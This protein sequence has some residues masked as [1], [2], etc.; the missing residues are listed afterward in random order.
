MNRAGVPLIEIVTK[1]IEGAGERAPEVARAY[2]TA[3]RD[4][5]RS[6]KVSDVN[7]AQGS[8]RADVN[9]SLRPVGTTEFGTRTETKNV[10]TLKSIE[11]AV[12]YE[13]CRQA[14][15]LDAGEEVRLETRH[16]LESTGATAAGRPKETS[17]DYRYFNDPDL[18]PVVVSREHVEDIRATLPELPWVRRARLQ[19][20]WNLSDEELL[21]LIHISEPTRPY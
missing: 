1:P 18:A 11:T 6:L 3:L 5:I 10:N 14:A 2:V 20:E 21:S 13:M 17:A 16:F 19:K 4:V 15:V 8:M 9:L 12:R 7:M